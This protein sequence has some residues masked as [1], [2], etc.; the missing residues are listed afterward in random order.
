MSLFEQAS[1]L[2]YEAT[3]E[4]PRD[5]VR[6]VS[7]LGNGE[8]GEVWLAQAYGIEQLNPRD[9][10]NKASE[11]RKKICSA[12]NINR[13]IDKNLEKGI[14]IPL[15]AVKK[16]TGKMEFV[17]LFRVFLSKIIFNPR[18]RIKSF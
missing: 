17:F 7:I 12:K 5:R 2:P 1:D 10:S 8:F 13:R 9:K 3:F 15:V 16:L 4:F 11:L 18:L 6:F 14:A